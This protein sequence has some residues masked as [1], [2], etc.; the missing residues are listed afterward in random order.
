MG[1]I[2]PRVRRSAA[3]TA[4]RIF[5]MSSSVNPFI[6]PAPRRAAAAE[7][8]SPSAEPAAAGEPPEGSAR[9]AP[10]GE[11]IPSAAGHHPEGQRYDHD[12]D[13]GHRGQEPAGREGQNKRHY[14]SDGAAFPVM[15]DDGGRENADHE[16]QKKETPGGLIGVSLALRRG[17]GAFN[18]TENGL[19]PE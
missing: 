13:G 18:C 14:A 19:E 2:S 6:S 15:A 4:S 12:N 17:V 11:N 3:F 10:T 16:R 5:R 1:T 8:A 7:V 9:S